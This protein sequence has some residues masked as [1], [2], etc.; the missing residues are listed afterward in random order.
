MRCRA[1]GP[2]CAADG[3]LCRAD[4]PMNGS[5]KWNSALQLLLLNQL[6]KRRACSPARLRR[7]DPHSIGAERCV[8]DS[9]GAT[10][11]VVCRLQAPINA[12]GAGCDV[13]NGR[14]DETLR[15]HATT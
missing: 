4:R 1:R 2:G 14:C 13:P 7:D 15:M 3:A 12:L 6:N 8:G 10:D 9:F 11:G 5:A